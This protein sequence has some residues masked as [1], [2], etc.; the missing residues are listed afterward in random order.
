M[1]NKWS[2]QVDKLITDARLQDDITAEFAENNIRIMA[3]EA[4]YWNN[5]PPK[6]RAMLKRYINGEDISKPQE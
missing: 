5:I 6:H 4:D 2:D 1:E 3:M